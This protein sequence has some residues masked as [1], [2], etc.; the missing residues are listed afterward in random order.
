M[1]ALKQDREEQRG[2]E[3]RQRRGGVVGKGV[4]MYQRCRL[5]GIHNLVGWGGEEGEGRVGEM[6]G[7]HRTG[8]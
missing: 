8:S 5:L 4:V 2:K 3:R 7:V 6:M 1:E